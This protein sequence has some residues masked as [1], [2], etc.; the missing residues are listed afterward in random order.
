MKNKITPRY[1]YPIRFRFFPILLILFVS[2]FF[3]QITFCSKRQTIKAEIFIKSYS[4]WAIEKNVTVGGGDEEEKNQSKKVKVE[5]VITR[6]EEAPQF[7]DQEG[8]PKTYK[9][10]VENIVEKNGFIGKIL[11][12]LFPII[13]VVSKSKNISEIRSQLKKY[14][15]FLIKKVIQ[16]PIK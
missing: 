11:R 13:F 3:D 2:V 5:V 1:F 4:T 14:H 12:E 6:Y 9:V 8:N 16:K 15:N 7:F 10:K